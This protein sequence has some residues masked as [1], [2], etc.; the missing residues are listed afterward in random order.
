MLEKSV[1]VYIEKGNSAEHSRSQ[2]S[3]S[4]VLKVQKIFSYSRRKFDSSTD[5]LRSL[6]P[7]NTTGSAMNATG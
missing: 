5:S 2:E 3:D 4:L 6:K 7:K 1:I